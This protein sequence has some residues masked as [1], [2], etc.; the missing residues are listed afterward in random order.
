MTTSTSI[1]ILTLCAVLVSIGIFLRLVFPLTYNP[2][3][4]DPMYKVVTINRYT[5]AVQTPHPNHFDNQ[6][7]TR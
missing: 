2:P 3:P 1:G 4:C 5:G 6:A 7:T